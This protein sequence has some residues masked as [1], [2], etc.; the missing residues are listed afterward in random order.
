MKQKDMKLSGRKL[1]I[2]GIGL[3]SLGA[4][5]AMT[6]MGTHVGSGLTKSKSLKLL[7]LFTRENQWKR[8]GR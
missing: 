6:P 1:L 5:L 2:L 8:K 3:F 4:D 7:V